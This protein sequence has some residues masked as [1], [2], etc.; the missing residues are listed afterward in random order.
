MA[1][2]T[3]RDAKLV[4][5]L[6]GSP[7]QGEGAG[8]LASGAHRDDNAALLTRSG[9]SSTS[10]R[11]SH[12]ARQVERGES[13]SSAEPSL[14]QTATARGHRGRGAAAPPLAKGPLHAGRGTGE[15]EIQLKN[16]ITEHSEEG[17]GDRAP[18]RRSRRSPRPSATRRLSGWRAVSVA[19]RSAWPRSSPR[20]IPQLSK[21]VALGGDPGVR[22]PGP[23]RGGALPGP[24]GSAWGGARRGEAPKGPR[25]RALEPF[26]GARAS[27][28]AVSEAVRTS[29]Q[30][31]GPPGN[32]SVHSQV[33]SCG[34]SSR[35]R[36][37]GS[38]PASGMDR[39]GPS[40]LVRA[41]PGYWLGRIH[42]T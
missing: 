7:R 37:I 10:G 41:A 36:W 42:L 31:V 27:L 24:G 1:E 34:R 11:P 35:P 17:R 33:P 29:V 22:A 19:R 38:R 9:S 25:D 4:Q 13:R 12:H 15:E 40:V 2:T 32:N 3:A 20:Q 28:G 26:L 39:S 16:A 5:Y 21:A 14:L 8:N 30:A 18:T 23:R 6:Q